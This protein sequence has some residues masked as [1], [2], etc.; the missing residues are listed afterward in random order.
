MLKIGERFILHIVIPLIGVCVEG[1]LYSVRQN[2]NRTNKLKHVGYGISQNN[3]QE[4][5]ITLC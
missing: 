2:N 4:L 1:I 5:M 3:Y